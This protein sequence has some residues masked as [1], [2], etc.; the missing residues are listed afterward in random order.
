MTAGRPVRIAIWLAVLVLCAWQVSRTRFIA[1]LSS[2][3]PASPTPEQRLLVDQLRD[4]ALSR[5]VLAGIEGADAGTRAALSRDVAAR[6]RADPAF[7]AV[8]NGG[9]A[10]MERERDLVFANRYALSPAVT[11][12]RFTVEGLRGAVSETLALL[13][14][15]AGLLVKQMVARDPTGETVLL[16]ERRQAGGGPRTRDGVWVSP[17]G[18]RALLIAR[19]RASGADIDGQALAIVRVNEA[20][21]AAQEKAGAAAAGAR[22]LLTGPGVFSAEARALIQDDVKRLSFMGTTVIVVLLLAV[23]RSPVVLVLGLAP[24]VTGALVGVA[25]V[26]LGYGV[27]HGITLGFGMTLI[28]EAVDYAIYLFVQADRGGAPEEG[29]WMDRFWPTIRLGVATSLA[30]FAALLFSDVPGLSQMGLYSMA[31]LVAAALV[32]RFVLPWLL[33]ATLRVRDLSPAGARLGAAFG[34]ARRLRAAT[35]A[36]AVAAA[37]LLAMRS[38]TV[39]NPDLASLNPIPERTRAV[40]AQLRGAL[41]APD[42]RIVVAVSAPSADAALESAERVGRGLDPL[43]AQGRLSGYE[44]PADLL[45]SL[46]TQAARRASLPDERTLRERLAGALAGL[47]L[48]ESRLEPFIEDVRRA[49]EAAPLTRESLAGTA[50]DMALDGLLY[51]DRDGR[52]TA[53]IGLRGAV[54]EGATAG[55]DAEA[56]REAVRA[57]NVPGAIVVDLKAEADDLYAGYLR[58]A[59]LLCGAGVIVVALLLAGALRSLRR[60]A[61]VLVPLAAAVVVVAAAHVLA[62]TRLTVP[63]LI[64]MVLVV[65]I[66]SNYALFFDTLAVR[67]DP[68]ANRT[69]ASLGLATLTTVTEFGVLSLSSIPVL[70]AIGSTVALGALLSLVFCAALAERSAPVPARGARA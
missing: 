68:A 47:P 20:F 59:L 28:G 67:H 15:P 44:S 35:L 60:V 39:W 41:G 22:L 62:G 30:G 23:F 17:E 5:V 38:G 13:A 34:Y 45:P 12:E 48:R 4:G 19:T 10:G 11:A 58:Q 37:V 18:D 50:F 69:Y 26:S 14:S 27:V 46:A 54:R 24:V 32:A 53:L 1:D 64:G 52:W 8:A 42:A 6:L 31:G 51:A 49:R 36:L 2:F 33:P 56:V 70:H 9:S 55:I 7:A 40:D 25:A 21:R 61:R 3:L 43:V 29:S 65:A 63:H 66:G 57:A 16:M